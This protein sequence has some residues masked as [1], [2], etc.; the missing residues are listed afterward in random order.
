MSKKNSPFQIG[1]YWLEKEGKSPNWQYVWYCP[2]SGRNKRKTTNTATLEH[3]IDWLTDFYLN[4]KNRNGEEV[5]EVRDILLNYWLDHG[6]ASSAKHSI[7]S[8]MNTFLNFIEIEEKEGRINDPALVSDIK[9]RLIEQ[10]KKWR[11]THSTRLV[12]DE[13]VSIPAA[14]SPNTIQTNLKYISAAFNWALENE[15][16]TKSPKISA[17]PKYQLNGPRTSFISIDMMVDALKYSKDKPHLYNFILA[18]IGTIA[19]PST[20]LDLQGN[21]MDWSTGYLNLNPKG[22]EYTS[23]HRPIVA[24]PEFMKKW[25]KWQKGYLIT[26][27]GN[28][29]ISIRKSWAKM[30]NDLDWP[31]MVIAKTIRHSI[32]KTFRND[33]LFKKRH[34]VF[35]DRWELSGHMGHRGRGDLET[36]EDYAQYE[37]N[38]NSTIIQGLNSYFSELQSRVDF[39]LHPKNTRIEKEKKIVARSK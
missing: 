23:K 19:R 21:M 10:Y 13:L 18:S 6:K 38:E 12:D 39:D 14:I 29:I 25:L 3:A 9:P 16:I 36:T 34:G 31:E 26:F 15:N 20:V 28:P 30:R 8:S 5:T 17:L 1:Q 24:V 27:N 4:G 11:K 37:P 32:N 22:R 33:T 2:K 35:I 7:K